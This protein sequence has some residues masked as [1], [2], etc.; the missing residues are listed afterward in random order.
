MHPAKLLPNLES[1][2]FMGN[3]SLCWPL[4]KWGFP[5]EEL[6]CR[7]PWSPSDDGGGPWLGRAAVRGA[8][9][10]RLLAGNDSLFSVLW[11]PKRNM[12]WTLVAFLVLV[13][14]L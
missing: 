9:L 12:D 6:A 8:P 14:Y 2:R 1:S 3:V 4:L 10:R 13:V 7:I 11:K 5:R